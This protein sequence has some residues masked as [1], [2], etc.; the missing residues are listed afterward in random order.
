MSAEGLERTSDG[1]RHPRI[2]ASS[3]KG[4]SHVGL[5]VDSIKIDVGF[6]ASG[7]KRKA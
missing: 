1:E 2:V 5:V 7:G 6:H 3:Q 4:I